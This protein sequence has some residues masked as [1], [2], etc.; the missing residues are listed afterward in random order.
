MPC[1][2]DDDGE[3]ERRLRDECDK[4]TR[5]LCEACQII[6]DA[7]IERSHELNT[8]WFDHKRQDAVR[9]QREQDAEQE[10]KDL[11]SVRAKLTYRELRLLGLDPT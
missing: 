6:E 9:R 8:W 11:E 2:Y 10:K 1:T 3:D 4:L 5:L 7:K